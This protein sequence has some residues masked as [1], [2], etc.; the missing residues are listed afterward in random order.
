MIVGPLAIEVLLGGGR[1]DEEDVLLTASVLAVFALSIPFEALGHLV[2]RGLYATHNTVLAGPG[3]AG[4]VRRHGRGDAARSWSRLASLAIPLGFA[5]GMAVKVVPPGRGP[6]LAG[7]ARPDARAHV[8]GLTYG[9]S[10]SVG[11]TAMNR[12][13]RLG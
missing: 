2:A 5:A 11:T 1:F 3:V 6:R 8:G 9:C 12:P 10:G 7:P 4:R 13:S